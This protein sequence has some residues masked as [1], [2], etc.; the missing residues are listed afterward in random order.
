MLHLPPG[1]AAKEFTVT[2]EPLG[3]RPQPT[4]PMVLVG[5]AS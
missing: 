1:M 5:A 4:G 3:G 2:I